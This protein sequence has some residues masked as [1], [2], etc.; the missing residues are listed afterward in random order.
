MGVGEYVWT[1]WTIWT[2]WIYI[3][4]TVQY[5]VKIEAWGPMTS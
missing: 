2:V 4:M 5:L 1:V 3:G